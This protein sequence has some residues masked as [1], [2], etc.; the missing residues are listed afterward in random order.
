MAWTAIFV[1]CILRL[2]I[3]QMLINNILPNIW[4]AFHPTAVQ[5]YWHNVYNMWKYFKLVISILIPSL[6]AD[7]SQHWFWVRK[8]QDNSGPEICFLSITMFFRTS[9]SHNMKT[10][11]KNECWQKDTVSNL[12]ITVKFLGH[13]TGYTARLIYFSQATP[14]V[15]QIEF[16]VYVP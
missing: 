16:C 1:T 10:D 3:A 5:F 13:W 8:L 12:P 14:T 7:A 4:N 6:L 11:R 15:R 9:W 2:V